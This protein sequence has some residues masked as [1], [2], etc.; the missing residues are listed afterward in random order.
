MSLI[1]FRQPVVKPKYIVNPDIFITQMRMFEYNGKEMWGE[2]QRTWRDKV[3]SLWEVKV[4]CGL[5]RQLKGI[6]KGWQCEGPAPQEYRA[7]YRGV[8]R[9]WRLFEWG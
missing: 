8:V 3:C 7:P 1:T 9:E 6:L 5:G 2:M 4:L